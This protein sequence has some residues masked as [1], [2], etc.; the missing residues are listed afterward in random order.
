MQHHQ[1]RML[2]KSV[3]FMFDNMH[4]EKLEMSD[5]TLLAVIQARKAR[6]QLA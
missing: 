3:D 4:V 6:G 1:H 5:G 2:E